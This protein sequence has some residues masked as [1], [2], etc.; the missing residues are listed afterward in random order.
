MSIEALWS[1]V[2]AD[3]TGPHTSGGV[4]LLQDGHLHGGDNNYHY[5]GDYRLDGDRLELHLTATH[6]HGGRNHIAGDRDAF[7]L[8]LSGTAA[9]DTMELAGTLDD[10]PARRVSVQLKRVAELPVPGPAAV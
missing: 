4:L 7:G 3:E 6:F 2:F 8:T 9:G 10:D 5:Q 1:A